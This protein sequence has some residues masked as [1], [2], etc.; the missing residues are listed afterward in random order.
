MSETHT[1]IQI[2]ATK[3]PD[4]ERL[5]FLPQ[6]FGRRM[7]RFEHSVFSH[8]ARLSEGYRGGYW[9][10]YNLSN[11]GCYMAPQRG[12]WHL[13]NAV[14]HFDGTVS[15]DAA[16]I[17][18]TLYALSHLAGEYEGEKIFSTRF[19]QLRDFAMTHAER[20]LILRAID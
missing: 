20:T 5:E 17:I 16:G 3:V 2:L 12:P 14:N 15:A 1:D 10:F 19:H 11:G 6:H 18:A 9:H 7:L 8:L 13:I 4:D